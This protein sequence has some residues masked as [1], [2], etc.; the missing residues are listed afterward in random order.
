MIFRGIGIALLRVK[1]V[2][3]SSA[4]VRSCE[5]FP[6]ESFFLFFVVFF[7]FFFFWLSSYSRSQKN[8]AP[9]PPHPPLL[10]WGSRLPRSQ[11]FSFFSSCLGSSENGPFPG[12]PPPLVVSARKE[13]TFLRAIDILFS[14]TVFSLNLFTLIKFFF[15]LPAVLA[16]GLFSVKGPRFL[17]SLFPLPVV[18]RLESCSPFSS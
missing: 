18:Q 6:R 4:E 13:Y 9:P 2:T 17:I 11:V 3:G 16:K 10:I 12:S 1:N 8:P 7:F 5:S 14:G 15:P